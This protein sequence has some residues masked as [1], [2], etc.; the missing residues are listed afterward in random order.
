MTAVD[1]TPESRA[2]AGEWAVV[3]VLFLA[4]L[5]LR[6]VHSDRLAVEHF[7]EG[8]YA[9][10][11]FCRPPG[12]PDLEFP[13]QHL[14]A[15]PL[16]PELLRW[17]LFFTGGRSEAVMWVS[18]VA[19]A[20]M[21]PLVWWI[22]R[23]WFGPAAGVM[24]AGLCALS[25]AHIVFSRMAMTDVLLALFLTAGVWTGVRA[26][27]TGRPGWVAVA[28]L[29]AALAWWTK[30]NG[31]LTLAI[32][33]A[34]LA[35]WSLFARPANVSPWPLVGRW[36]AIA[37]IAVMLWTPVWW[38][39]QHVGGYAA[40]AENH[41]RYVVGLAGW[42]DSLRQQIG[43]Q[44]HFD[45]W[46]GWSALL[47]VPVAAGWWGLRRN[48]RG[49]GELLETCPV[50]IVRPVLAG[51]VAI[52]LGV[53]CGLLALGGSMLIDLARSSLR[54]TEPTPTSDAGE[55]T[56]AWSYLPTWVLC[57]WVAGLCVAAPS[58]T[59]YPRLV[60]PLTAGLWLA[61]SS[62]LT[63]GFP[64]LPF[65][66]LRPW[67]AGM[68]LTLVAGVTWAAVAWLDRGPQSMLP[69]VAWQDRTG[70]QVIAPRLVNAAAEDFAAHPAAGRQGVQAV[71]YVFAEPALFFHLSAVRDASGASR[72]PRHQPHFGVDL[73]SRPLD[74]LVQPIGDHSLI[75]SGPPDRELATFVVAG[76]HAAAVAGDARRF[77]EAASS[78]RLREVAR[79]DYAPSDVVLL[80]GVLPGGL[81]AARSQHVTLY[82]LEP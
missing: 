51:A 41:S 23:D 65:R 31:W 4:G 78:G 40:V 81:D 8:V 18:I 13:L 17:T 33:G 67:L 1:P 29:C 11:W 39:L 66:G 79:F 7:D 62:L 57:A 77:H 25:D 76:P 46:L 20:L 82:R 50:L 68:L 28:G 70:L 53:E 2:T 80:D 26:L 61:A 60:L 30:Y 63:P 12:L 3:G 52:P 19:G 49:M 74:Y 71:L 47:V 6:A 69:Q 58:Y 42:W 27:L 37:A 5:S 72:A 36:G 55:D 35:G 10:N 75:E 34:G 56:A 43:K 54:L 16:L 59:S 9:S 32:T 48:L 15:P 14:Y 64:E 45:S 73:P 44:R 21:I 24:A 38:S 22:A